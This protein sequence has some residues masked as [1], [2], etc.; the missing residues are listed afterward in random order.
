MTK[1][2]SEHFQSRWGDDE[3]DD[4]GYLYVPGWIM[5]NYHQLKN[6]KGEVVGL[7]PNEFTFLCH[8]MCFKY[9]VPTAQAK[10]SLE[11][12]AERVGRH[13]SNVRNWKDSLIEKGF[14]S[15]TPIE[16]RPSVYDF[17]PLVKQCRKLEG[18]N[19]T[20]SEITRGSEITSPTPSE[21]TRTPLAK[22]LAEESE[23]KTED[24]T[25]GA[26][27]K[28]ARKPRRA[29]AEF[30]PLKDAIVAAF[31]WAWDTMSGLEQGRVQKT[32]AQLFDAGRRAEDVPALYAYCKKNYTHFGPNALAGAVSEVAKRQAVTK[33]LTMPVEVPLPESSDYFNIAGVV[34]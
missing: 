22:S 2:K 11:T 15:V 3:L 34:S 28:N 5:R 29:A 24:K 19:A 14:L 1:R 10:P 12:I 18:E 31:G 8:V 26:Q 6:K 27:K 25:S 13:V 16:G 30:N 9:D 21:I 20:P 23:V 7:T 33:V 4:N 17:A 32:A